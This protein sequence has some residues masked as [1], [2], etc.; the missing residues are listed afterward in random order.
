MEVL[1][2]RVALAFPSLFVPLCEAA[3]CANKQKRVK[4]LIQRQRKEQSQTPEG[5]SRVT[6][7]R[8]LCSVV[9]VSLGRG[10][11]PGGTGRAFAS[12]GWE[13]SPGGAAVCAAAGGGPWF[14]V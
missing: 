13:P 11:R 8:I 5:W 12:A 9:F 3:L 1:L 2:V 14:A 4:D 6:P 10:A 7:S